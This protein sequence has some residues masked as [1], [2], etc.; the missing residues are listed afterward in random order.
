MSNSIASDMS[1]AAPR[2]NIFSIFNGGT[3]LRSAIWQAVALTATA[4]IVGWFVNNA[5]DNLTRANVASGFGF[6]ERVA[7][8]SI[9]EAPIAYPADATYGR[10]L[11]VGLVNGAK[12]AFLSIFFATVIGV[13][14][15]I[16][17]LS[18]HPVASRLAG[19]YVEL[20]RN[21]PLLLQLFFWYAILLK[22]PPARD[23]LMPFPGAFLSNRGLFIPSV[24]SDA[25]FWWLVLAMA[26]SVFVAIIL[27]Y[28]AAKMQANTGKR[29]P[30][31]LPS[32]LF[33]VLL[34][35]ITVY[36][37]KIPLELSVPHLRGF[38]FAGGVVIS[39]EF[40]ALLL[41]LSLYSGAYIAE[42][43]RSGIL[44]VGKGQWEAASAI[45]LSDFKRLRL[46]VM[47]QALRIIIPPMIS[48]YGGIIKSTSLGVAIGFPEIV[49]VSNTVM[50]QT[51]QAI[52]TIAIVMAAFLTINLIIAAFLNWFNGRL[53]YK[54][55]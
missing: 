9:T 15:G 46:V 37:F 33:A 7:G 34:A 13:F 6:L 5:I 49:S 40:T 18:S 19:V 51:G 31:F 11:L 48:S 26:L 28:R 24:L 12:V 17:R 14:V 35:F 22:M 20:L 3:T 54:V 41:G 32:A 2:R 27:S 8:F 29:P 47:P 21:V 44:S 23:A 30:V 42:T 4:I 38:N 45:G 16:L 25:R 55:R 39:P 10:A 50:N 43:V 53:A 52:E 36:L 1:K